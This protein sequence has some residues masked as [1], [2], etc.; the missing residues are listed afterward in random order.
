V[1]P[2]GAALLR[3]ID[4]QPV[5]AER[6]WSLVAA[7]LYRCAVSVGRA[8][9]YLA[10]AD[11]LAAR[12]TAVPSDGV[13]VVNGDAFAATLDLRGG[14]RAVLVYG[15]LGDPGLPK[16][17]LEIFKGGAAIVLDD[18]VRLTVHGGAG[19]SLDLGRQ[20]KGFEG[21]WEEIGRALRGEPHGV[22][23]LH[24]I[25]AAMRA[26]FAVARAVRGER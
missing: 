18:F 5:S 7:D 11:L 10:G 17:R 19:G 16:E 4:D 14:S 21:Q 26:T 1:S 15:G 2:A 22:I 3:W 8:G 12:A 25:E 13:G 9:D 23:A 24:E 6:F 20:D